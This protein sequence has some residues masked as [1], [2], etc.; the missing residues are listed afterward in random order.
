MEN[1]S[2]SAFVWV[3]SFIKKETEHFAVLI[4]TA[5][6]G[7]WLFHHIGG[8]FF[9]SLSQEK[10]TKKSKNIAK[11]LEADEP[12][13]SE[14]TLEP[15][16]E[17]FPTCNPSVSVH[18]PA[19]FP[20]L[21]LSTSLPPL[22]C[23]PGF[24]PRQGEALPRTVRPWQP[25][26]VQ[27]A[28][29]IQAPAPR[30]NIKKITAEKDQQSSEGAERELGR[31]VCWRDNGFGFIVDEG[32]ER[33]FVRQTEVE[34]EEKLMPG[35]L[36]WFRRGKTQA[37]QA[38]KAME[39]ALVDVEVAKIL[40]RAEKD[41]LAW[42]KLRSA[43]NTGDAEVL[44]KF[45]ALAGDKS[46]PTCTSSPKCSSGSG[47]PP[48]PENIVPTKGTPTQQKHPWSQTRTPTATAAPAA[49]AD[50]DLQA[51]LGTGSLDDMRQN[52]KYAPQWVQE[53]FVAR[54]GA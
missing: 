24:A 14:A 5:Y 42:S 32:A 11:S 48:T 47:T 25:S 50:A 52:L 54:H 4:V 20:G 36:V 34:N 7:W 40:R 43:I 53:K 37:N 33:L 39:V 8:G 31:V 6:L 16:A 18:Q 27:P 15:V 13:Q 45:K 2:A 51:F 38:T 3:A 19:S 21:L 28:K 29:E 1:T 30:R 26:T 10:K 46:S 17:V 9:G 41:G 12:V 44:S 35:Q 49:D 22:E 23:P